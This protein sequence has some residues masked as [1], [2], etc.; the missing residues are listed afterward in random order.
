MYQVS[1]YMP[2]K[3]SSDNDV[4]KYNWVKDGLNDG[5][6]DLLELLFATKNLTT[7]FLNWK[8]GARGA[9]IVLWSVNLG[10]NKESVIF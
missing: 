2:Y 6:Q 10:C 8:W 5:C 7:H 3:H 1:Q 9:D 4:T